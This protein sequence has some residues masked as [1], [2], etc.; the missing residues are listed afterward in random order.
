MILKYALL[1]GLFVFAPEHA[2][3]V[4]QKIAM[5]SI[6]AFVRCSDVMFCVSSHSIHLL[7]QTDL[8]SI[9]SSLHQNRQLKLALS[10]LNNSHQINPTEREQYQRRITQ[11]QGKSLNIYFF[12]VKTLFGVKDAF[13]RKRSFLA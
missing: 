9:I 11:M 2:S 8:Q 12:N 10:L 6:H 13:W 1:A 4:L 5:C 3:T 7:R